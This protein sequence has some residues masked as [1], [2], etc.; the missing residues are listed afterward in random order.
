MTIDYY[1]DAYVPAKAGY[2]VW[3]TEIMEMHIY[4]L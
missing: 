4:R 1:D 3:Y 2:H